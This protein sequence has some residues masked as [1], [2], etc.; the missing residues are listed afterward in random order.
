MQVLQAWL[1]LFCENLL[2]VCWICV[3]DRQ[4]RGMQQALYKKRVISN[5]H[6][7][8]YGIIEDENFLSFGE[9]RLFKVVN[10]LVGNDNVMT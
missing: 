6:S 4:W 9:D 7:F 8:G 5:V 3:T 10:H 2:V 1:I